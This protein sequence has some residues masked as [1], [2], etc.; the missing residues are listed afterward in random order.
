MAPT[1]SLLS[2]LPDAFASMFT[3]SIT[4]RNT[5]FLRCLMPSVRQLTAFVTAIGGRGTASILWPSCVM[6]S[7]RIFESVVCG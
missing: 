6:Y 4:S 7:C 1:I 2:T 5:S 3:L